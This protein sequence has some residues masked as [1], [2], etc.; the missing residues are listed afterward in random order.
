MRWWRRKTP[1]IPVAVDG[2]MAY[3]FL[4]GQNEAHSVAG[5]IEV[6]AYLDIN[7][8][9]RVIGVEVFGWPT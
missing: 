3:I 8:E 6:T 4:F 1:E 2:D 9:G 7:H 5:S